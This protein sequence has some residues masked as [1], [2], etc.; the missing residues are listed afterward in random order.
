MPHTINF[1][2]VSDD[3]GGFSNFSPHP[4]TLGDV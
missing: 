3:Y 2:P 4:I 1:Y